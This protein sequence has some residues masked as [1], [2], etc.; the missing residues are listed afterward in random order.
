MVDVCLKISVWDYNALKMDVWFF[1]KVDVCLQDCCMIL[2][3]CKD[4]CMVTLWPESSSCLSSSTH[5]ST[6]E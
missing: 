1:F 2:Y 4:W 5:D 3:R 6:V